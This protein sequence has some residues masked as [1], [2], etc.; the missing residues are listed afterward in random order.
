[1][2]HCFVY[3]TGPLKT[4]HI[5]LNANTIYKVPLKN[6]LLAKVWSKFPFVSLKCQHS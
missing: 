1:M 4:K 6:L 2:E 3:Q 5:F